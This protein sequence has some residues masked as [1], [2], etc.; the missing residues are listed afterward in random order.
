MKRFINNCLLCGSCID[1][2]P[3]DVDITDTIREFRREGEILRDIYYLLSK[4]QGSDFRRIGLVADI[5]NMDRNIGGVLKLFS[6]DRR[7]PVSSKEEIKY[8][9]E[10][11]ENSIGIFTGCLSQVFYPDVINRISEFYRSRGYNVYLPRLQGCCGLMNYSA[12][13][14]EKAK[15]LAK[16]NIDLFSSEK[17]EKIITPCASCEYMLLHYRDLIEEG[18]DISNKVVSLDDALIDVL[19]TK[20]EDLDEAIALH[21]PC[22]IRNK[23]DK[24]LYRNLKNISRSSKVEVV[25]LCCG[26]GGVFNAYEYEKSLKIG[27]AVLSK[28]KSDRIYTLCSGCYLQ[29]YDLIS[30]FAPEKRVFNLID[31]L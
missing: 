5:L 20:L 8:D 21:I 18:A 7:L 31:I 28:I 2:C 9:N 19:H 3:N 30:R 25:D 17:I 23:K 13:D 15:A 11:R 6:N 29:F 1:V 10:L 14:Y 26:Y 27:A 24:R 4:I 22:H 12:G 16:R